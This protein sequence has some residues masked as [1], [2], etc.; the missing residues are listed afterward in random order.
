M[1]AEKEDTS[2]GADNRRLHQP[3]GTAMKLYHFPLSGH[4]H[5][6][7]LFLGLLGV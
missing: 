4:A 1:R 2:R 5:R 7:R 3:Q 6:A